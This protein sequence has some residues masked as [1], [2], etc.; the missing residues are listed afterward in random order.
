MEVRSI[1]KT[2]K[3]AVLTLVAAIDPDDYI[4][5]CFDD[6]VEDNY[7]GVF[8]GVWEA[9]E[10]LGVAS[11]DF[12]SSRVAWLQAL[13]VSPRARRRGVG[14]LLSQACLERA[15]QA[16]RQ[17]ARLLIDMD[18]RASLALTAKAGF[19]QRAAWVRFEKEPEA[20]PGVHLQMPAASLLPQLVKKAL[21]HGLELWHTDWETHDMNAEALS[22][23]LENGTLFVPAHDP[24]VTMLDISYDE[25]DSEY[26]A[27][28]P[29]GPPEAVT[30]LLRGMEQKAYE[31]DLQRVAVLLTADSSHVATLE[32]LGYRLLTYRDAAGAEHPDGVTIWEHKLCSARTP[33]IPVS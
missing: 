16:G 25:E 7:E 33:R 17:V 32:G 9:E 24:L 13:R 23:S 29:F 21:E 27:Y 15:G 6:W 31:K 12:L 5:Y 2:D 26:K 8:L 14:R 20:Q 10:L 30:E 19:T 3:A 11:V 4:P 18:N 28:N 22:L 1:N